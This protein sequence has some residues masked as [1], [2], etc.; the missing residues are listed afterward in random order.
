[1]TRKAP[2]RTLYRRRSEKAG[3]PPDSLVYVGDRGGGQ[4]AMT[5]IDYQE[6][7]YTERALESP[8]QCSPYRQS[9]STTWIN[10]EG[11]S[12]PRQLEALGTAMGVHS[13][14]LEDILD[15]E[16]RPKLEDFDDYLFVVAK[17]L[18]FDHEAGTVVPEHLALVLGRNYLVSFQ[19]VPGDPFEP[20]R[21][22]IRTGAGR[23]RKMGADFLLYCLLDMA[24][25]QYLVVLDQVGERIE[26]LDH[27]MLTSQS[28]RIMAEMHALKRDLL[29]LRKVVGPLREVVNGLLHTSS[30]LI[31]EACAPFFR[32][33]H[34][35]VAHVNDRIE[36]Y[37]D[38]L[39]GMLDLH[40]TTVSNR[41][42]TVMKIMAVF[43][44][45]FLP[46]TFI[47]GLFGMNFEFMPLL[48][49]REGF[50]LVVGCMVAV[51]GLM[52]AL[53]RWRRWI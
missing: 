43:S 19:E 44:S 16:Q 15:T 6:D 5:L 30:A 1:L 24:V 2:R 31:S 26:T 40:L 46:L 35:H 41:T 18:E 21:S 45:V 53:F 13:L 33:L 22:R 29:F 28:P 11:L 9:P 42:N 3:L 34:D 27:Q 48:H 50:T 39:S 47:T 14:V 36:T 12:Q 17:F 52:L 23:V 20:V 8:R 7:T 38:L 10:V 4:V 25:D 37:R 51:V 49:T 32:D